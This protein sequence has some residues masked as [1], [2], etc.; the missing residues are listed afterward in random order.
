MLHRLMNLCLVYVVINDLRDTEG[1][2]ERAPA[3]PI[4]L[5]AEVVEIG[6]LEAVGRRG[7]A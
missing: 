7:V 3:R 6:A 2:A 5:D 4:A 1:V